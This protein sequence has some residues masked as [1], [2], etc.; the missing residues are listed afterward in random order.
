MAQTNRKTGSSGYAPELDEAERASCDE[1]IRSKSRTASEAYAAIFF[2]SSEELTRSEGFFRCFV[3]SSCSSVFA[4]PS[5]LIT[6]LKSLTVAVAV[7]V[8][9]SHVMRISARP[10]LRGRTIPSAETTAT[11]GLAR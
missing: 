3:S 10:L 4:V 2:S 7:V 1:M 9:P 6:T 8:R 5:D 11:A